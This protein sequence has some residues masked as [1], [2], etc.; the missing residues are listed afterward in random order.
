MKLLVCNNFELRGSV[1]IHYIAFVRCY[2][3]VLVICNI[4]CREKFVS[5]I[6]VRY[7]RFCYF[8]IYIPWLQCKFEYG[9][10]K[11]NPF[12]VI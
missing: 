6:Y 12:R 10:V 4:I 2:L 8:Y 1:G 9:H 3:E 5:G 7:G 11:Q